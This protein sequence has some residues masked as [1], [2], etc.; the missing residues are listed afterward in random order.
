MPDIYNK[1]VYKTDIDALT[2]KM[3]NG[4]IKEEIHREK[5]CGQ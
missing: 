5:N 3:A 2:D 1:S 4:N